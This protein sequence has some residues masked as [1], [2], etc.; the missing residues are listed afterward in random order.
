MTQIEVLQWLEVLNTRQAKN[1]FYV[2]DIPTSVLLEFYRRRFT[3]NNVITHETI[4]FIEKH[5][6]QQ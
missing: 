4:R 3:V 1:D 5:K 6:V 2:A